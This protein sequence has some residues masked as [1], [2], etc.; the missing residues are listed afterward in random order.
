MSKSAALI[1]LI[2]S[3][4]K[5]EK[6]AF[7]MAS[8]RSHSVPHYMSLYNLLSKDKAVTADSLR[9]QYLKLH[10]GA[11]FDTTVKY[12]YK[13]LLDTMLELRKEQDSYY[14]LFDKILKA[15]ILFEKSLFE[16]CFD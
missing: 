12:L 15:R 14:S 16:E 8:A 2:N 7:K 5:P 4:S 1:S 3:M 13:I 10:S 9:V 11:S 6:K